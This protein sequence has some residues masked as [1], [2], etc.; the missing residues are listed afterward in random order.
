MWNLSLVTTPVSL[1]WQTTGLRAVLIVSMNWL[2][3][4]IC[5]FVF[6]QKLEP[7][8]VFLRVG[9]S[10]R[11]WG[12]ELRKVRKKYGR[13]KKMSIFRI[14]DIVV[15][16]CLLV[17]LEAA[18]TKS[19]HHDYPDMS[20]VRIITPANVPNWMEVSEPMRLQLYTKKINN[21]RL[22]RMGVLLL[23]REEHTNAHTVN[24]AMHTEAVV[25][26]QN[27]SI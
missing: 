18:L 1:V 12:I 16:L 15:R 25:Y 20:W 14:R 26:R 11:D 9:D 19:H 7:L 4:C 2:L 22:L 3:K 17:T 10:V 6:Y 27:T 5:Y 23:P 24:P 13:R 21:Q 8:N